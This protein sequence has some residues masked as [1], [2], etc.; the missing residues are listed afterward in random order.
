[1]SLNITLRVSI[2]VYIVVTVFFALNVIYLKIAYAGSRSEWPYGGV[3]DSS[4]IS[5]RPEYTKRLPLTFKQ[6]ANFFYVTF[7]E[8]TDFSGA[9]FLGANFSDSKFL[10]KADFRYVQFSGLA[11]FNNS[12]FMKHAFFDDSK[13]FRE[14]TFQGSNFF[15]TAG[16]MHSKFSEKADFESAQFFEEAD[17]Q[18]A[19]FS[20][21]AFFYGSKFSG[22]ANFF[23]LNYDD[24]AK[25]FGKANFR[26][27]KFSEKADFRY[28]QFLGDA[29]F[30]EVLFS[31]I[32][33]FNKSQ[34]FEDALFW[35]AKFFER[36][37]FF[38]A[39]FK[40]AV[41]FKGAQFSNEAIFNKALFFGH[42]DFENAAFDSIFSIAG[43]RFEKGLDL[44]RANLE[45]VKIFYDHHTFFPLGKLKVN[46]RQLQGR[47]VFN[48]PTCETYPA[49]Q[50][51]K[52]IEELVDYIHQNS[53]DSSIA[54]RESVHI[55]HNQTKAWID[56]LNM[57]FFKER[58]DLMV[59]FYHRLR[60]NYLAQNNNASADKVMY[61]LASKRAEYLNEPYWKL[62]GCFLGW[63][64]KPIRFLL[65]VFLLVVLPF[66]FLWYK[67]FYHRVAPLV[68]NSLNEEQKSQLTN[69]VILQQKTFLYIFKYNTYNHR[70]VKGIVNFFARFLHVVHFSTTV[71]LS[72]R[73][74]K[75]WIEKR[76]L[77]FLSWVSIEWA[78]GIG[79]YVTFAILVKSY[80]FSYVKG[81]L[82]F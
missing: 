29:D 55:R 51:A 11:K 17:F 72:I 5:E 76:D 9:N 52:I 47:L 20:D 77:A 53:S 46:W 22:T 31:R 74:K 49:L 62:Y 15:K 2:T 57:V 35:N 78:L 81:L 69:S 71:L 59:I 34:F 58:Y 12:Q 3:P 80:E 56:S 65:S 32:A 44:R 13:F 6:D 68:D 67:R 48:D 63:G 26:S 42:V 4:R 64:Y 24:A 79:L 1:M 41:N 61:E 39:Q 36:V 50:N 21:K 33:D 28:V 18:S 60:D 27:S 45:N 38:N 70:E 54:K 43:A 16:F 10:K 66:A 7:P 40:R 82:G 25:F 30:Y 19:R 14:V 37:V 23:G 75:E 73:F 8:K